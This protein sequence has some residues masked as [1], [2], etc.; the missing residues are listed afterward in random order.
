MQ[1][2]NE[3]VLRIARFDDDRAVVG[4]DDG[5]LE[6][7]LVVDVLPHGDVNQMAGVLA[8]MPDTHQSETQLGAAQNDFALDQLVFFYM[9][10]T[11]KE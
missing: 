1:N 9:N 3:A 10:N 8:G 5:I 7:H 2:A 4:R 11:A 6:A